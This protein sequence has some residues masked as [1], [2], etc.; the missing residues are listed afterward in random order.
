MSV[1]GHRV[2]CR[3]SW[4]VHNS[5]SVLLTSPYH[6]KQPLSSYQR[7]FCTAPGLLHTLPTTLQVI[8]W[9]YLL[10]QHLTYIQK[11]TYHTEGDYVCPWCSVEIL[12]KKIFPDI[13]S[14]LFKVYSFQVQVYHSHLR[15]HSLTDSLRC[16]SSKQYLLLLIPL[17]PFQ[18]HVGSYW[19]ITS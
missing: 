8:P 13:I 2:L 10:P 7:Q 5:R 3:C 17:M 9:C 1:P 14:N 18:V 19:M 6:R 11:R 12:M 16:W 15:M 4:W